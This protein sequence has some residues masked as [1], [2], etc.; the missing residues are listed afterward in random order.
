MFELLPLL[1]DDLRAA[2][3]KA[4]W[5]TVNCIL[6]RC[7]EHVREY[8]EALKRR[9]E[10]KKASGGTG[11]VFSQLEEELSTLVGGST[12]ERG[13]TAPVSEGVGRAFPSPAGDTGENPRFG[14]RETLR[15]GRIPWREHWRRHWKTGN[16]L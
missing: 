11:S 15:R 12:R 7:W 14:R 1:D 10:E 3:G 13:S 2:S 16:H 4:R 6:I 9:Y 5:N 8:L